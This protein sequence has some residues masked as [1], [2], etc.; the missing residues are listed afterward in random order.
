[1]RGEQEAFPR[2][3]SERNEVANGAKR[4]PFGSATP[5]P[6]FG[7]GEGRRESALS[8]GL[9]AITGSLGTAIEEHRSTYNF[10]RG[11]PVANTAY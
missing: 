9:P 5:T 1:L 2:L 7:Q 10:K 11:K 8:P 4:K 6:L 3:R